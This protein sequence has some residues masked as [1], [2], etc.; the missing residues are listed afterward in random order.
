MATEKNFR[1]RSLS[2]L[3]RRADFD[4]NLG[5]EA[6][7]VARKQRRY[8]TLIAAAGIPISGYLGYKKM[9]ADKAEAALNRKLIRA[10]ATK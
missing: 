10:L 3:K 2:L 1:N 8:G 9:K 7:D 5:Q 6:R 4:Y